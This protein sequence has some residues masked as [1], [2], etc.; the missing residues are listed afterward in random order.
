MNLDEL[1][2]RFAASVCG[3][4]EPGDFDT[5]GMRVYANNYRGQ[6]V[7]TLR[8][9]HA[10]TR[11]WLGDETFDIQAERYVDA[12]APSSWTIDAY[13]HAFPDMLEAAYPKDPDVS[14]LAWLDGALHQVFGGADAQAIDATALVADDWE[15]IEF[16]FVPSVRFRRMRSNAV[17]I[18]KA[19]AEETMPPASVELKA[20]GG[21]R[22]W[23]RG[24][25]PQFASMEAHECDCLDLALTGATFGEICQ[26]L[27]RWHGPGSV[28]AEAGTL[29][30][31][32]VGDGLL[33]R[34]RQ[35]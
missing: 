6:L 22:V 28:A 25:S 20:M 10:K 17:A 16:V 26:L 12:H 4:R 27:G 3:T 18:W 29:L 31:A 15:R 35:G 11:L 1:Q 21:V 5:R 30:R 23:R 32:W 7:T 8:D 14:E 19:L 34:L 24:L 2:R 13:G 33:L 9:I